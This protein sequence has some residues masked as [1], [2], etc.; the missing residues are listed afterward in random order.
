MLVWRGA[1]LWGLG[2]DPAQGGT[3]GCRFPISA[4]PA[5]L[6]LS[7]ESHFASELIHGPGSLVFPE[8]LSVNNYSLQGPLIRFQS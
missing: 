8:Q 5:L 6:Q 2:G 7:E 1:G 3:G 4:L